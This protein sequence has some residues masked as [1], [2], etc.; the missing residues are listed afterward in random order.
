MSW[1][2]SYGK[3]S[4]GWGGGRE[5]ERRV[6]PDLEVL[7]DLIVVFVIVVFFE[8]RIVVCVFIAVLQHDFLVVIFFTIKVPDDIGIGKEEVVFFEICPPTED[9]R[10]VTND[11]AR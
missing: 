4:R 2:N 9:A 8:G 5:E 7:L 3:G 1:R 10:L 11:E 6:H